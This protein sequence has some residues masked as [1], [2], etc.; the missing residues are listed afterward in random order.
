M[1]LFTAA[2]A[3]DLVICDIDGCLTPETPGPFDLRG[4]ALIAE[5]N[6]RAQERRDRP[7]LTVCSGRPVPYVEAICRVIHNT[8]VPA[9][10]ENGVW[11]YDPARNTPHIDPDI[12]PVQREM[13]QAAARVLESRFA[14]RGVTLQAGKAASV[15]L[16]HAD[17][18]VLTAI[19]PEVTGAL[20]QRQWPFRVSMS[21]SYLNCDLPHISKG[22]GIRRLL[23]QAEMLP[24]RTLGIGDTSADRAIAHNVSFFAC[25]AN[26]DP[27][28]QRI[29][30]YV[31]PAA[32]VA[33]VLDILRQFS[34]A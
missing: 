32:E 19:L 33:G 8:V 17:P 15:T 26:A 28:L 18:T 7:L 12:T 13:V 9:V 5:H 2:G 1:S 20:Q 6:R 3:F 30:G 4:L 31:S 14:P 21:W 22:T 34:A 24:Q 23:K 29:A 10:A 16:F 25:P 27:E 11:L